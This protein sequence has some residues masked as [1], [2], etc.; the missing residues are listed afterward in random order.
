MGF[1]IDK[2]EERGIGITSPSPFLHG[3]PLCLIFFPLGWIQAQGLDPM[4]KDKNCKS[5][6]QRLERQ[7]QL[8]V[9]SPFPQSRLPASLCELLNRTFWMLCSGLVII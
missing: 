4:G 5:L 6:G 3:L 2:I 9:Q 7:L 8:S 1:R